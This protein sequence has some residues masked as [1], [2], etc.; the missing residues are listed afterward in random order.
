M[1]LPTQILFLSLI[2]LISFPSAAGL[3]TP[4]EIM[5]QLQ[6]RG[7]NSVV[8]E[9]G[10]RRDWSRIIHN[11]S[12]GD[13][14]WLKV[15]FKLSPNLHPEFT[16]QT[17]NA[18]S[19]ALVNNPT[20]VLALTSKHRTISFMDIC[21][22]PTTITGL[23]QKQTFAKNALRSLKTVEKSDLRK[24]WDNIENCL[25]ELEKSSSTYF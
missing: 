16:K 5:Q 2:S 8:A 22:I 12:T 6:E 9:L 19:L 7:V 15:A 18:L 4:E 11:I 10:E 25:W 24:N 13:S 23:A 21:H 3:S 20:E 14:Q 17:I 1:R